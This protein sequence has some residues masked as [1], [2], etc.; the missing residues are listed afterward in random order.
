M[1]IMIQNSTSNPHSIF[2]GGA[3]NEK[4]PRSKHRKSSGYDSLEGDE[5]SSSMDSSGSYQNKAQNFQNMQWNS[6]RENDQ[7]VLQLNNLNDKNRAKNG[8]TKNSSGGVFKKL[9]S[10]NPSRSNSTN[11]TKA[12]IAEEETYQ[13]E[14]KLMIKD[15]NEEISKL[16]FGDNLSKFSETSKAHIT[17]PLNMEILQY[18]EMDILRMDFRSK[19]VSSS[20]ASTTNNSHSSTYSSTHS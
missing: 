1:G 6:K 10:K 14:D 12:S 5:E 17:K 20:T 15:T 9:L 7:K 8:T 18:D 3:C 11:F 19:Q 13:Y 2:Y 4:R 16:S